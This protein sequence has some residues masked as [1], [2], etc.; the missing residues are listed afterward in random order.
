MNQPD[1]EASLRDYFAASA[2]QGMLCNGIIPLQI[3]PEGS[4]L[5]AYNY[6]EAAYKMADLMIEARNK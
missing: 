4:V 6:A 1:K 5:Q 2:L 3:L